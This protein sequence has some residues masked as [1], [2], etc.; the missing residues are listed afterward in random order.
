MIGKKMLVACAAILS[1]S[2]AAAADEVTGEGRTI[3]VVDFGAKPDDG[4]D[5][6]KALRRAAEY[7]RENA[8]T[9]LVMPAGEYRLR[10]AEAERLEN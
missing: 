9:T 6:T 5:D 2:V 10:D 3:S 4:K 7:C 1:L 8:G